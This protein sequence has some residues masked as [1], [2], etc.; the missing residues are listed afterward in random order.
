MHADDVIFYTLAMTTHELEYRL[1]FCIDN[2][3]HWFSMNKL[4]IN[5]KA[6]GVMVIGSKSQLR[7]L[8]LDDFV[9]SV[10]AD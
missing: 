8:N 4:G 9:Y 7:S 3:S 6:F 10:G 2:T 5:K 1:H